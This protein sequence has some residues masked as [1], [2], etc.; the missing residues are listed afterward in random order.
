MRSSASLNNILSVCASQKTRRVKYGSKEEKMIVPN[1]TA[2]SIIS[3]ACAHGLDEH[4]KLAFYSMTSSFVLSY[5]NEAEEDQHS[6]KTPIGTS[7][8]LYRNNQKAL[9]ES[10][11]AKSQLVMFVSGAGGTG[12]SKVIDHVVSYAKEYCE[13]ISVPFTDRTIV[14]TALT[15]IAAVLIKGETLHSATHVYC[16]NIKDEMIERWQDARLVIIDEVSFADAELL[17]QVDDSLR[18]LMQKP[19]AHYG[20]LNI[21]FLGD[22]RQLE[23]VKREPLYRDPTNERWF[24]WINS[25][26]ELKYNHRAKDDPF[27]AEILDRFRNGVPTSDD[28]DRLNERVIQNT[29]KIPENTRFAC[30]ANKDRCAINNTIFMKHLQAT[31]SKTAKG[32]R[33]NHTLIIGASDI[34]LENQNGSRKFPFE[35]ILYEK[36]SEAD[37]GRSGNRIDPCLKL[38]MGCPLMLTENKDVR[39][40]EANGCPCTLRQIVLKK[41]VKP[42]AKNVNGYWVNF[43]K[44]HQVAYLVAVSEINE[45]VVFHVKCSAP[46]TVTVNF[47]QPAAMMSADDSDTFLCRLKMRQIHVHIN[48]ATTGHKLQGTSLDSLFVS[49]WSY[50]R[51]WP[52]VM[53]SRVRKL[54]GLYLRNPL[55]PPGKKDYS[56]PKEL[57]NM[58]EHFENNK[59]PEC[60]RNEFDEKCI[61]S[62]CFNDDSQGD[63]RS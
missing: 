27:Y 48:N 16:Q 37:V 53:L 55:L 12:K 24:N 31:H 42:K 26:I 9:L 29:E 33:P 13:N 43:V 51:N 25:Y 19:L 21:V 46:K 10:L 58:I 15:G 45:N 60:F 62:K 6:E 22:F 50:V 17:E 11:N 40:G 39:N 47:P 2:S 30:F 52:Y 41:N 23:P 61:Y 57:R 32:S 18:H 38:Y 14:V 44:A 3:W 63:R 8:R 56:F 1:G 7:S 36:C 28:I 34:T 4:Q 5:L 54:S 59:T 49:N 20:G 35:R